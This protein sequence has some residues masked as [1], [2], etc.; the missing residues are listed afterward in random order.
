MSKS[1]ALVTFVL[2]SVAL[3]GCTSG[4]GGTAAPPA[5][6]TPAGPSI[7]GARILWDGDNDGPI[8]LQDVGGFTLR[9]LKIIPQGAANKV[10]FTLSND[11]VATLSSSLTLADDADVTVTAKDFG[12]STLHVAVDTGLVSADIPIMVWP[13]G[14]WQGDVTWLGGC[15]GSDAKYGE[16]AEIAVNDAGV[17]TLTTTDTPGFARQYPITI[18]SSPAAITFESAGIFTYCNGITCMP[19]PGRISIAINGR[20]LAYREVTA[21]GDCSNLYSG[22]LTKD[23]LR[24]F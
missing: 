3:A 15:V 5:A 7:A 24:P 12:T 16:T 17:G 19:V 18:P 22:A 8:H 2:A 4:G 20:Q 9:R 21:W 23:P 14:K 6:A 10:I 13:N 11:S 1:V